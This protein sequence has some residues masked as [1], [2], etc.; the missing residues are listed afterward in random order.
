[1]KK[2]ILFIFIAFISTNAQLIEL[3]Q[4]R[5]AF[6]DIG[7]G[8]RIPVGDFSDF[9]NIGAGFSATFSYTD[10][11]IY[12]VFA[13]S[14]IN[15]QH[16]SGLQD[17]YK[18]TNYTSLSTNVFTFNSGIKYFFNPLIN[19]IVILMPVVDIGASFGYFE[20]LHQFKIDS[21]MRNYT[22]DTTYF[23][24]QIGTGVS[25]FLMDIIGYYN[26]YHNNQFL[27][28]DLKVRIPVYILL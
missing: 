23:G 8:P 21:G 1:M 11:S 13:Y 14:S 2:V 3:G 24:F 6:L 9:Q 15:Y 10:N 26:Y 25:M 28:L 7:V 12:P 5:G 19:N 17:L 18:K 16:H 20:K 4:A 27:S 22:E